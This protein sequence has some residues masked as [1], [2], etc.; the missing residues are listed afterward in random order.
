MHEEK[1]NVKRLFF[2]VFL[3][4]FSLHAGKYPACREISVVP[5]NSPVVSGK[6]KKS[7]KT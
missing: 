3:Q 2:W 1:E 7:R 6:Q 4:N 5:G